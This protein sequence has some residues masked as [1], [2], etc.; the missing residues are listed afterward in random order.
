MSRL[1][2][3]NKHGA[4]TLSLLLLSLLAPAAV[5]AHSPAAVTLQTPA[6]KTPEVKESE[7]DI[8]KREAAIEK[9][10]ADRTP[11]ITKLKTDEKVGETW[12]GTLAV[13]NDA[14]LDDMIEIDAAKKT[15]VTLREFVKTENDDREAI[16]T[17]LANRRST[18]DVVVTPEA[19]GIQ[20]GVELS[21]RAEPGEW[22]QTKT[23]KWVRKPKAPQAAGGR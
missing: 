17:I 12:T 10:L 14:D 21:K 18:K 4:V 23:G 11:L 7:A 19:V 8:K 20:S 2:D 1:F 3:S 16:Y 13:R 5:A 9:R 22:L 6:V 15:K